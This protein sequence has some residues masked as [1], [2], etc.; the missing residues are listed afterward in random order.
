MSDFWVI[1]MFMVCSKHNI[2]LKMVL[3]KFKVY[4][5]ISDTVLILDLDNFTNY[6]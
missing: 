1:K 6:L 4:Y 2:I 5:A 3:Q